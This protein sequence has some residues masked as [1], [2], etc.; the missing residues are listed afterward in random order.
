MTTAKM[1]T[2][3]KAHVIQECQIMAAQLADKG[4]DTKLLVDIIGVGRVGFP[5]NYVIDSGHYYSEIRV[6][7]RAICVKESLVLKNVP[8]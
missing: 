1:Q 2:P 7:W 3:I 8:L 5:A 6:L 4:V